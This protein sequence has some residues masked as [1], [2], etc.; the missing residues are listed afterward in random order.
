MVR[1]IGE[2]L[3][4]QLLLHPEGQ[5][6]HHGKLHPRAQIVLLVKGQQSGPVVTTEGLFVS[7][8]KLLD[9]VPFLGHLTHGVGDTPTI[10]ELVLVM[11]AVDRVDFPCGVLFVEQRS[12]EKLAESLQGLFKDPMGDLEKEV[13][14]DIPRIGVVVPGVCG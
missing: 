11:F 5:V 9:R 12:F 7:C 8:A 3:D 2:V 10:P 13:G 1:D 14:E 6:G 4:G